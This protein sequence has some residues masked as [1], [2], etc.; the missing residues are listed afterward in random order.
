MRLDELI[1]ELDSS[2]G[3]GL[4]LS[5]GCGRCAAAAARLR[6]LRQLLLRANLLFSWSQELRDTTRLMDEIGRE[7]E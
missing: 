5:P 7:V 3:I 4:D 2:G 1:A 6:H